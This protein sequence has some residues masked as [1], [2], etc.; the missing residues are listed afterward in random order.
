MHKQCEVGTWS[1]GDGGSQAGRQAYP[2]GYTQIGR[3]G[4]ETM[5]PSREGRGPQRESAKCNI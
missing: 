4:T 3:G 1:E 2:T 5:V